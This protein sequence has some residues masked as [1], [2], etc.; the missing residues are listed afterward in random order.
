MIRITKVIALEDYCLEI[1][2]ENGNNVILNLKSRLNTVRF[3]LL[4][5]EDVFRSATTDGR[6][7]RWGNKLELS[8]SEIFSLIQK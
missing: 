1:Q 2:L 4:E 8:V 6:C 7:V 3:G 5:E